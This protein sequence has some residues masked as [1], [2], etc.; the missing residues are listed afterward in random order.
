MKVQ[1]QHHILILEILIIKPDLCLYL[2]GDLFLDECRMSIGNWQRIQVSSHDSVHSHRFITPGLVYTT[3]KP[4][5]G[6]MYTKT[7]PQVMST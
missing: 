5:H 2:K 7:Q 4:G 1:C 6:L 3:I